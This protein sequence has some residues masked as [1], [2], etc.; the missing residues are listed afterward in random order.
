MTWQL[1]FTEQY[2]RKSAKFIEQH[3]K[4]L[5]QYTKALEILMVKQL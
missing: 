1:I 2:N 5:T 4:V 3:T